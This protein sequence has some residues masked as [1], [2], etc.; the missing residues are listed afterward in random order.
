MPKFDASFFGFTTLDIAGRPVHAIPD[1]GG[2]AF[3]D[4]I[5]MNPAGTAAGAVM[6]AAKM[7][8]KT[9]SVFCVGDDEKG[10]FIINRYERLKI[11]CA[12]AQRSTS[13]QTST[14]ILPIRPNG[15][16]PALHCRGASDDLFVTE[17]KFDDVCDARFL[18]HGGTG[19]IRA[20]EGGQSAKLLRH[21]KRKG[22]T[23]TFDLIGPN[24]GTLAELKTLLPHVD[25]FMPSLEEAAH[26]SSLTDPADCAAFFMDLG[27]QSCIFKWGS[28][29][30]FIK[31]KDTQFRIP[32]YDVVVSDTTGCG[33]SYCGGFIA[34]LALGYDLEEACKLGTAVSGLVASGLG[35]DAVVVDL[36]TTKNFMATAKTKTE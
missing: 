2:I 31:T 20:M 24:E 19:F 14:T 9:R 23:V 25:Y 18:H 8:I 4:E 34:G 7:G 30:S 11:D 12:M 17:D 29:G 33:D 5:R 26:I 27:A 16:R 15:D 10:D 21:A 36:E 1:G 28:K 6:N 13:K 32:A 3:L 35:S 22:L